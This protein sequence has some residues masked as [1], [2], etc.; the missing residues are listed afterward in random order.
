MNYKVVYFSRSGNSK[1]I[2]EKISKEL[3]V[4]IIEISCKIDWHGMGGIFRGIFYSIMNKKVEITTYG[5]IEADD[6]IILVA[7]IWAGNI[8]VP[9]KVFLEG[10]KTGKT[11]LVTSSGSSVI[12]DSSEFK[13]ITSI[14]GRN[15]EDDLIRD[16]TSKLM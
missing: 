8:A 16:L 13:S 9:A 14:T 15:D 11:H 10:I 2:A 3:S 7:P 4:G 5:N 6:E 12:A 1:R